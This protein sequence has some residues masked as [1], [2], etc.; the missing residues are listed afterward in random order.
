MVIQE[1]LKTTALKHLWMA[2]T[3]WNDLAS[4]GGPVVMVKGEGA[5][6][7]DTQ[8][9]R[10]LDAIGSLEASAVGHGRREIAE[11]IAVQLSRLDFADIFRFT[12]EPTVRLARRI[13]ELAPGDLNRV[14]Y[15]TSG[16][17]AVEAA[18][19]IARQYHL[20][21][22]E[23]TRVKV[24]SRAGAYHGCTFGA[25]EVDGNYFR[26]KNEFFEPRGHFGRFVRDPFSLEE[27]E[28]LIEFERPATVAA[29][30]LDPLG[31]ASG[32][33]VPPASYLPGVRQLCDR[34]GILL[35]CDEIITGFGRTGRMFA[36]EHWD[37]VPDIMTL[38]KGITSGY[39]PM[40]AVVVRD[41]VFERFIGGWRETLSHG[42]TFGG[43]P[44]ACAAALA[45]IDILVRDRLPERSWETGRYMLD[46]LSTL[47]GRKRFGA[48]RGL[49]LLCG[50]KLAKDG[51]DGV[52][53]SNPALAGTR[54][55][56]I[57][58]DL[59]VITGTLHPGDVLLFSP[60]LTIERSEI[61][62]LVNVM[63]EVLRRLE[64]EQL[65]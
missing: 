54:A 25:M 23:P 53:F 46:G 49:G 17:E 44:V 59:G 58:R 50:L 6:L 4:E 31:T 43:H 28:Q 39:Q 65:E 64:S 52:P 42:H 34:Y 40:A 30:I 47:S 32:V 14:F 55:R 38:S 16:S 57:A 19:K 9:K 8:G 63:D 26:T 37:V 33:M 24:V 2:Y 15:T 29:V 12:T 36:C 18:I 51:R 21:G 45:N 48:A 56:I 11:A 1:D 3:Q 20:L 22:G 10:Y 61:D 27:L 13:A 60:P 35:I 5:W 7:W 62:F 41:A